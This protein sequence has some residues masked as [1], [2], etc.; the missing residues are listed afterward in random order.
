MMTKSHFGLSAKTRWLMPTLF[1]AGIQTVHATP[2]K[3]PL[4]LPTL[5]TV[6]EIHP[7]W[8]DEYGCEK[9]LLSP[10]GLSNCRAQKKEEAT[11]PK[12]LPSAAESKQLASP[13]YLNEIK[14]LRGFSGFYYTPMP[15]ENAAEVLEDTVTTSATASG[16]FSAVGLV[17]NETLEPITAI[18]VTAQLMGK[19]GQALTIGTTQALVTPLRS[20][21]PAP[22]Q[23]T[24]PV[25]FSNVA[26][27]RWSVEWRVEENKAKVAYRDTDRTGYNPPQSASDKTIQLT[28]NVT[29]LSGSSIP[30]PRMIVAWVKINRGG[31][32]PVSPDKI[33]AVTTAP[34]L[35]SGDNPR[36]VK[37]FP[38]TNKL[39][40]GNVPGVLG[41]DITFTDQQLVKIIKKGEVTN[42]IWVTGE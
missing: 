37:V 16:D 23:L 2:P 5:P 18:T 22:F 27:V 12:A 1:L 17:R 4:E 34:L 11:R 40:P 14:N 39:I 31:T 13:E 35:D 36:K 29:N 9:I 24:V 41:Y 32:V 42:M 38:G 10:E 21:E 7:H 26:E 25:P 3:A 20:G 19:N 28:G 8:F 6:E 33:I 30:N 15:T